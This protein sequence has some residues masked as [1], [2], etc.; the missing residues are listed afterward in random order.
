VTCM[1]QMGAVGAVWELSAQYGSHLEALWA[2]REEDGSIWEP[3]APYGGHM[4]ASC[5]TQE[6]DGLLEPCGPILETN[7]TDERQM[8]LCGSSRLSMGSI[9]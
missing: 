3:D 7:G 8:A 2:T 6:V 4:G 5:A 9:W 1:C